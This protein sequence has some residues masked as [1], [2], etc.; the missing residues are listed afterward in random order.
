[1]NSL[2]HLQPTSARCHQCNA[3]LVLTAT[4]PSS[5]E[6]EE[7]TLHY[8]CS[9]CSQTYEVQWVPV[10]I[11]ATSPD[12]EALALVRRC[13]RCGRSIWSIG[14]MCVRERHPAYRIHEYGVRST[15]TMLNTMDRTCPVTHAPSAEE[16]PSA[17]PGEGSLANT[18]PALLSLDEL[19]HRCQDEIW[20]Y[21]HDGTP[22]AHSP[23]GMELYRRAV[24]MHDED[25]WSLI[26]DL[27]RG[28]V[29]SWINTYACL[30][31]RIRYDL[32]E[33]DALV[34]TVFGRFFCAFTVEHLAQC[35]SIA[36]ILYYLK[37]CTRSTVF[38]ALRRRR[39][40]LAEISLDALQETHYDRFPPEE[41]DQYQ[42]I[43]EQVIGRIWAEDLWQ[44]IQEELHRDDERALLFLLYVQEMRPAQIARQYPRWFPTLDAVLQ[45]QRR[46]RVCLRENPRIKAILAADH[47]DDAVPEQ[48]PVAALVPVQT[49]PAP[50]PSRFHHSQRIGQ[51]CYSKYYQQVVHCGKKTCRKCRD[52]IGHGP[53]WYAYRY[54]NG[55]I[56]TTYIGKTLPEEGSTATGR[57]PEE[58][59]ELAQSV[60]GPQ[61]EMS[62]HLQKTFCGKERCRKCRAG[63]GHGPY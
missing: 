61:P 8:T 10:A 29:I 21:Q 2:P 43:T 22:N 3:P 58:D 50:S 48:P 40:R 46:I 47:G 31:G 45:M 11:F 18:A 23:Y 44:V 7:M 56:I 59:I 52:G 63:E 35:P 6:L 13:E 37:L 4:T 28:L 19:A 14:H 24:T 15:I 54:E 53:Y 32:E 62:Y 33:Q 49:M 34:N 1:M 25:A 16:C 12:G 36:S 26:Y 17:T 55:R 42:M 30:K 57:K 5:G 60:T 20:R 39:V 41:S 27:Y 51:N 9:V 38:D